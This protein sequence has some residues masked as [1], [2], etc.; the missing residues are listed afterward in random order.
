[1]DNKACTGIGFEV[2]IRDHIINL[3]FKYL[4]FIIQSDTE[5]EENVNY[6]IQAGQMK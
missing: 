6:R 3:T 2:K 1:M 4:G 5:I